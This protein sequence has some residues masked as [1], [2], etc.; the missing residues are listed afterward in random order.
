MYLFSFE[1]LGLNACV[2]HVVMTKFPGTALKEK[3]LEPSG[4]GEACRFASM[5]LYQLA[6]TF[7]RLSQKYFHRDVCDRNVMVAD[8]DFYLVFILTN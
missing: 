2:C 8:E 1:P 5:M 4:F 3:Q 7:D 6:P